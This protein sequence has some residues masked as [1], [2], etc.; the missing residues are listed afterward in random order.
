MIPLNDPIGKEFR[1]AVLNA[2]HLTAIK[3]KALDRPPP[4]TS[5]VST[6]AWVAAAIVGVYAI[7]KMFGFSETES[8]E[9]SF[10][11]HSARP[12]KQSR[13]KQT[14]GTIKPGLSKMKAHGGD[15]NHLDCTIGTKGFRALPVSE[16][17]F[18]TYEHA[19]YDDGTPYPEN[20]PITIK[21]L[22]K[23]Y[24]TTFSEKHV[25]VFEG[26]DT[27]FYKIPLIKTMPLFPNNIKKF[28]TD[29]DVSTLSRT[30]VCMT[31]ASGTCYCTAHKSAN[32]GYADGNQRITLSEGY[33]YHT[34]VDKGDCGVPIYVYSGQPAGRILGMHV[35]GSS[36]K[37]L[38]TI[39]TQEMCKAAFDIDA[40][41]DPTDDEEEMHAQGLDALKGPNLLSVE[42][43]AHPVHMS[44][45][46]KLTPSKLTL[47]WIPTKQPAI[48]SSSDCRSFLDPVEVALN[49]LLSSEK[50]E[51]TPADTALLDGVVEQMYHNYLNELVW[52][53]AQRRLTIEEAVQGIPGILSSVRLDSSP[54]Y[55][56]VLHSVKKG[57][58][59]WVYWEGDKCIITEKFRRMVY[60][61]LS[62]MASNTLDEHVY[63]A[64]LKDELRSHAK[65][66]DAKTRVIYAG[67]FVATVAFRMEFGFILAAFN[68]N[69]KTTP[70]AIGMNQY[71][72]DMQTAHHYLSRV[73][74]RYVA[75]DYK[76]FD[77]NYH[78]TFQRLVYTDILMKFAQKC[79]RKSPLIDAFLTHEM[80]SPIQ[81][82]IIKI[83][84]KSAHLS[85]CFFTTI[86]NC[87]VNEAYV[88]Y[89][90]AKTN[91]Y[92]IY[93][94]NIRGKF[95]GDD[96][97]IC[98]SD[99]VDFGF[100]AI[101]A[102]MKK[103]NQIY[104]SDTKQLQCE[105]YKSFEEITFLGA[106]PRLINGSY[107]GAIKKD[108]ATQSILW[109]RNHDQ[110]VR[111]ECAMMV[112]CVSQWD[113][114]YYYYY[115]NTVNS[116][117]EDVG[118][119]V[120]TAQDGCGVWCDTS[121]V[122]ANRKSESENDF[123]A[124]GPETTVR[125]LTTFHTHDTAATAMPCVYTDAASRSINET[126]MDIDYAMNSFVYRGNFEWSTDDALGANL[127]TVDAPFGV[128]NSLNTGTIQNMAFK[129]FIYWR[130]NVEL[131]FQ[132]TG[133]PF[134]QG[135]LVA[136]WIP[137]HG[138]QPASEPTLLSFAHFKLS[139]N[140]S[141]SETLV[142]PYRHPRGALNSYN[143][144]EDLG[145]FS[146]EVYSPLRAISTEVV[147]I[148]VYSRFPNSKFSLP[149]PRGDNLT[150]KYNQASE[151]DRKTVDDILSRKNLPDR[152]SAFK[153]ISAKV[154][155]VPPEEVDMEA[156]GQG[157]SKTTV[158][159]SNTYYNSGKPSHGDTAGLLGSQSN[160][161]NV[162]GNQQSISASAN[163][164]MDKPILASGALP[165]Q[166]QFSG[167]SKCVGVDVTTALQLHP[168]AQDVTHSD[169]FDPDTS[170]IARIAGLAGEV[171]RKMWTTEMPVGAELFTMPLNSMMLNDMGDEPY[172]PPC[173]VIINMFTFWQADIRLHFLVAR[174]N[175]QNGRLRVTVAY[176]ANGL[177]DDEVS[178]YNNSI[179]DF[180]GEKSTD[181]VLIKYNAA[182]EFLRTAEG[183]G[184]PDL[185]QNYSLGTLGVHVANR[186]S[187]TSTA[188]PTE[189]EVI[190]LVSFENVVVAV[191]RMIPF[192]NWENISGS[193][194]LTYIEVKNIPDAVDE[195]K[196][197][198]HGGDDTASVSGTEHPTLTNR[199]DGIDAQAD[200]KEEHIEEVATDAAAATTAAETSGV[201]RTGLNPGRKFE[202][203]P[204]DYIEVARRGH[205]LETLDSTNVNLVNL[206][207]NPG[208][209]DYFRT[210]YTIPI[211]S[212]D[213]LVE[214]FFAGFA[215]D[216]NFR[217]YVRDP[218]AVTVAFFPYM[219]SDEISA[220]C[221]PANPG[222]WQKKKDYLNNGN[223]YFRVAPGNYVSSQ[224]PI[225]VC[226]PLNHLQNW[227]SVN[228]PFQTHF[229]FMG[230]RVGPTGQGAQSDRINN[231][232]GTLILTVDPQAFDINVD[233]LRIFQS[234]GD[235]A[236]YG[237]FRPW[238]TKARDMH[239]IDG[240]PP[241]TGN[242]AG[243]YYV[244]RI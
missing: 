158:N 143:E 237:V 51:L 86:M 191:P 121:R 129:N 40:T 82:G 240:L 184:A 204:T 115:R 105:D 210:C 181:S 200:V 127:Y 102:E 134:I 189:V 13:A 3:R 198:A 92:K 39:I 179:L 244:N 47:P 187:T 215:G 76:S 23:T 169:N 168:T 38:A 239:I 25:L 209:V 48:L 216:L 145:T 223:D 72:H 118:E 96:H 235:A 166:G 116:A 227:I 228:V 195:P 52:P 226:Y 81:M 146:V 50:E 7:K 219:S 60:A 42:R 135:I 55:P 67:N 133:S 213:P 27:A 234:V 34:K 59:D 160:P 11:A 75:G 242:Y 207:R 153:S 229:S 117:L 74:T 150:K 32:E 91:P 101:Q 214:T 139:P 68:N 182:T 114:A 9:P 54:G 123:I 62:K 77:K 69:F 106:H 177:D 238:N 144:N 1:R 6:I 188:I 100:N 197:I 172:I 61:F 53:I 63:L 140:N 64:Y 141:R 152:V 19:F 20:T 65:V 171:N 104:T 151:D 231:M 192:I 161:V 41:P 180:T 97:V 211:I 10:E 243:Y 49:E 202:F 94:Q 18:I 175:Y 212:R 29:D 217:I 126:A 199:S 142:A 83:H 37:G 222:L 221:F 88:R 136:R 70:L 8:E 33:V 225:E 90:F 46:S 79:G 201:R 173:V 31:V 43:V 16:R 157:G 45:K 147:T 24:H 183:P 176:G 78:P 21:Y 156:Q 233:L 14:R 12:D 58:R 170:N 99:Q 98:V 174:T 230:N 85:G 186:L 220:L 89:C 128:L 224:C 137:L 73:G 206:F 26:T 108:I 190:L 112:Q 56:L 208:D 36:V 22:G 2:R 35:A 159:E 103:I 4:A 93:D 131:M 193:G 57:K 232:W 165:L 162:T 109:T 218:S 178:L 154:A 132:I 95:M 196:M 130:G 119:E 87:L 17:T 110:T 241:H 164:P 44:T 120:L 71:S 236:H 185:V 113:E 28:V 30:Q 205:F 194:G 107:S 155:I 111:E 167:M 148:S 84:L 125:G 15:I 80:S 122:V 5:Y 66:A 138:Y 163:I 124:H 149:R 203:T